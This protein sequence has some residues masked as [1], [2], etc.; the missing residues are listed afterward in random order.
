MK[1]QNNIRTA[2]TEQTVHRDWDT[3]IICI[4]IVI[5]VIFLSCIGEPDLIDGLVGLMIK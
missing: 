5:L 4:T 2:S 3:E 1:K